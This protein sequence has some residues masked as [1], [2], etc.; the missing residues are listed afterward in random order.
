MIFFLFMEK[1]IQEMN[2]IVWNGYIGGILSASI[3]LPQLYKMYKTKSSND[4][5]WMFIIV[6]IIASIFSLVYYIQ[7]QANPMTYTNIF[8][9]LTRLLLAYQK[10]YYQIKKKQPVR[11][12]LLD[13]E[14]LLRFD[15]HVSLFLHLLCNVHD[16]FIIIIFSNAVYDL[17]FLVLF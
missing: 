13:L 3:F 1:K 6:S 11:E 15:F 9:M 12:P 14:W 2:F 5:S 8:S 16:T 4:I 7:I 10:A 17:I